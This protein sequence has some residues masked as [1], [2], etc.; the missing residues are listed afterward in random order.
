MCRCDTRTLDATQLERFVIQRNTFC[1]GRRYCGRRNKTNIRRSQAMTALFSLR[2][3]GALAALG[4]LM[5]GVGTA[6]SFAAG[7]QINESSASGLG[8]A[9]AGGAA[10]AEDASILW[11]NAAGMIRLRERQVVG[12]VHLITPSIK[13][14]NGSSVA[15]TGQALGGEGGDA[16]GLNVVP[17]LYFVAPLGTDWSV[18]LG[19]SSPFGLV[20][21]YGDGWAGR[22]QAMKSS[23]RTINVNPSV[24][25]RVMPRVGVGLGLNF[26][27]I[28]AEFTNQVNFSGA[29]L[30]AAQPLVV[31]GTITPATLAAI[32]QATPNLESRA[33]VE[34]SDNAWGWNLGVL[35]EL[36]DK[37]RVGA[38]Y[39]SS[40]KY[41]ID[42]DAK[43][44]N[45]TPAATGNAPLDALIAQLATGVNTSPVGLRDTAITS[46]V[47]LPAIVNLSYFTTLNDR[48]DVLA[49]AQWTQWSTIQEL[50]FVRGNGTL[51]QNTPE[52]FKDTW[53]VA[54]GAHYRYNSA[55]TLRGGIA[56]DQS[57][58]RTADRTPR[59]PD[60][61]RTWLAFGAQYRMSPSLTLDVGA[62]YVFVKKAN[63]D[64]SGNPPSA[65]ANGTLAGRYDSN[66]IIAS[67]QITYSF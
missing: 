38:Q 61:D 58:V 5:L 43:F 57:P 46:Q 39:R 27:R 18:G 1:A 66:T 7:F 55:L 14:K 40:I 8:T 16:G 30:S 64:I 31:A 60:A 65:A 29:L 36:D 63:I 37:T 48:W 50:R 4:T 19:L 22:F 10:A 59:L 52:N 9:Y 24:A 42:G 21:E 20:T 41:T 44:S 53:K 62:A 56:L 47:K 35:W 6:P 17:N 45:P 28:D 12:A 26:Q 25:W 13:F 34:G 15:A 23:I 2:H 49:D 3:A 33:K 54:L 32:A 11:S 51:L 67:G